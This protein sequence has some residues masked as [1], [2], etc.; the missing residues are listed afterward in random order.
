M[1][2]PIRPVFFVVW[3]DDE[4]ER[5]GEVVVYPWPLSV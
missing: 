5:W 4:L 2:S 3:L 1:G